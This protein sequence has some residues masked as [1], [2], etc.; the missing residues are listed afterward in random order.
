M[1]TRI[2]KQKILLKKI[3]VDLL[4]K[5]ELVAIQIFIILTITSIKMLLFNKFAT[6]YK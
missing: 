5:N 1:F 3:I 6:P 4:L 2:K